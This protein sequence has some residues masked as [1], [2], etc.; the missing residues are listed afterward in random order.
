MGTLKYTYPLRLPAESLEGLAAALTKNDRDFEDFLNSTVIRKEG[1]GT[2][3]LPTTSTVGGVLI[4]TV[5][6]LNDLSDVTTTLPA[7]KH[8]LAH[9]GAGQFVNRVLVEADISDLHALPAVAVTS[10]V[11]QPAKQTVSNIHG[12]LH[13]HYIAQ[14]LDSVPTDLVVTMGIGKMIIVVNAGSDLAGEITI[15]GTTVNPTTG[16]ETGSDTDTITVDGLTTDDSTTDANGNDVWDFTNGYISTKWFT[17]TVT[18]STTDLTLTDV[19][20]YEVSIE[21]WNETPSFEIAALDVTLHA[22]NIAAEFD[23]YLFTVIPTGDTVRVQSVADVHVG[24]EGTTAVA[25]RGYRLRR[26]SLAVAMDGTKDGLFVA[27]TFANSP[28][29]IEDLTMKVWCAAT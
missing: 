14:P 6:R 3:N 25:S 9:N 23:C 5:A 10:F 13:A 4:S 20:V 24:A 11:A 28:S 8:F 16:A 26:N 29:Y 15:T 12:D 19:D 17:G 7:T 18:L 21:A 1:D 2:V 27:M 22:L